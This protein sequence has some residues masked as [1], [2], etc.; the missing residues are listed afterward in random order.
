MA[1]HAG[2]FRRL[3]IDP[4][5]LYA[6]C[7]DLPIEPWERRAARTGAAGPAAAGAAEPAACVHA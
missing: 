4:I 1:F 2:A 3:E 7:L 5:G 6:L